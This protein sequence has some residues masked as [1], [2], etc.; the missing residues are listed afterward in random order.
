MVLQKAK[1]ISFISIIELIQFFVLL[2]N[3]RKK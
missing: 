3:G 2:I 1:E